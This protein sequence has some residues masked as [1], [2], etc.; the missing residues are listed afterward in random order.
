MPIYAR[1]FYPARKPRKFTRR[2][3]RVATR[4]SAYVYRPSSNRHGPMRQTYLNR[5]FKSTMFKEGL[6][7]K[8]PYVDNK[9][10]TYS[11]GVPVIQIYRLNSLYDPDY[12]GTGSQPMFFDNLLGAPSGTAPYGNYKVT[13]LAYDFTITNANTAGASIGRVS[14]TFSVDNAVYPSTLEEAMMNPLC[15][16]TEPIMPLTSSSTKHI[17][18]VISMKK[19][20]GTFYQDNNCTASYSGNPSTLAWAIIQVWP[21]DETA[22]SYGYIL[23]TKFIFTAK[24]NTRNLLDTQ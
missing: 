13:K 22:G 18:G 9:L 8:F 19:F 12:T 7:T 16:V 23:N 21:A 17:K 20:L 2:S 10:I 11:S 5:M 3:G 6:V 15:K 14:I 4:G 1:R 24:L